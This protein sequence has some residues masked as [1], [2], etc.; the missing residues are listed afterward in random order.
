[1]NNFS[2]AISNTSELQMDFCFWSRAH[3]NPTVSKGVP[4][5]LSH[6][7]TKPELVIHLGLQLHLKQP[8][9]QKYCGCYLSSINYCILAALE[10]LCIFSLLKGLPSPWTLDQMEMRVGIDLLPMLK[11][12]ILPCGTSEIFS[13]IL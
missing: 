13:G 1:M 10:K 12:F 6:L 8:G 4:K 9:T 5:I 7:G 2:Y 11:P 3:G